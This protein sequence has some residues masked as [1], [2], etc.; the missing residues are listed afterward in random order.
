MARWGIL[1]AVGMVGV[2]PA[3]PARAQMPDGPPPMPPQPVFGA[4]E[5]RGADQPPE[6]CPESRPPQRIPLI[7][8]ENK[9][10]PPNGFTEDCG[11]CE[12]NPCPFYYWSLGAVALTRPS[13]GSSVLAVRDP[14][15]ADT[16]ISPGPTAPTAINFNNTS[17]PYNWGI[18][19][20]FGLSSGPNAIELT[21]FYLFNQEASRTTAQPGRLDL[22]FSSFPAP[23]G[24]AGDKNL[25]LQADRVTVTLATQVGN[26]EV[27]YRYRKNPFFEWIVGMRYVYVQERYSI[28]T[29]DDVLTVP[30]ASPTLN[31]TYSTT[32]GNN[33]VGPQTGFEVYQPVVPCLL[34][35]AF[36]K[37]MIGAN[38]VEVNHTLVRGDGFQGPGGSRTDVIPS[39]V[40]QFGAY[41]DFIF[42]EHLRLRGGYQLLWLTGIPVAHQQMD[43]DPNIAEGTVN[44]HGNIYFHGPMV[45]VVFAF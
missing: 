22:P 44:N 30:Q 29:E 9:R 21:G 42:N 10:T 34:L 8:F 45:E 26:A 28:L 18:A 14:Q 20:T 39:A 31:A 15:T 13:F 11:A 37:G 7:P 1:L 25:W 33:I 4:F 19:G 32:V 41:A 3:P 36:T 40:I 35:G 43:F 16:G 23:T 2:I 5:P 12:E 6:F 17:I 27:N 24:F 38:F